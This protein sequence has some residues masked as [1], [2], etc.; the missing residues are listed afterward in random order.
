MLV[1]VSA[2]AITAVFSGNSSQ[3]EI[4]QAPTNSSGLSAALRWVASNQSSGGSFGSYNQH[5][6]AAAAYALWLNNT[7]SSK[8]ALSYSW[9]AGQLSDPSWGYWGSEADVPGEVLFSVASSGN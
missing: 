3:P 8:A 2:S 4:S 6:A 5:W 9:L 7:H 1:I